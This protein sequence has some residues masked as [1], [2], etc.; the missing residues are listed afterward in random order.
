[1]RRCIPRTSWERARLRSAVG[2]VLAAFQILSGD[3]MS[4]ERSFQ[5]LMSGSSGPP[6]LFGALLRSS[7]LGEETL[8]AQ[9]GAKRG[10]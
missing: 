9:R 1:M 5:K 10:V 8:E 3:L 7:E 6:R 4:S 2:G